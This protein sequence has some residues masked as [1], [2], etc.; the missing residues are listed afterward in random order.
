[1]VSFSREIGSC[2]GSFELFWETGSFP[3][4]IGSSFREM[5]CS[6]WKTPSFSWEMGAFQGIGSFP[7][8]IGSSF[9]EMVSSQ[10]ISSDF[11][12]GELSPEKW[13]LFRDIVS[14]PRKMGA[15]QGTCELFGILLTSVL[16]HCANRYSK[17]TVCDVC[18]TL[19]KCAR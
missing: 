17:C 15:I 8:E 13:D 1:M 5:V 14:F 2:Q 12:G 6:F 11:L 7:T 16:A 19:V 4:K 3:T 10:E 9:R 18:C